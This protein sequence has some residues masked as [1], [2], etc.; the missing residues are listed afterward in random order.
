MG[1]FEEEGWLW[2]GNSTKGL[3][4]MNP[5][6]EG[7]VIRSFPVSRDRALTSRIPSQSRGEG[8]VCRE[9]FEVLLARVSLLMIQVVV[10]VVV[11]VKFVSVVIENFRIRRING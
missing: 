11:V 10:V 6:A 9:V 5:T 4:G 7:W 8:R 3:P 1:T 2:A